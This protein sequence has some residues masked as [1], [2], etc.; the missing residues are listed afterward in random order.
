MLIA[1]FLADVGVDLAEIG[2]LDERFSHVF[3][4]F[5]YRIISENGKKNSHDVANCRQ[6]K[7]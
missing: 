5:Y 3:Q 2:G 6:L 1:E 4:Y 7:E